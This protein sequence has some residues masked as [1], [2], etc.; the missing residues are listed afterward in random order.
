MT[1]LKD[2]AE[3]AREERGRPPGRASVTYRRAS[4]RRAESERRSSLP[5]ERVHLMLGDHQVAYL[6]DQAPGGLKLEEG[7]AHPDTGCH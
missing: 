1:R 7:N 6:G 3:D 4:A 5:E 2:P